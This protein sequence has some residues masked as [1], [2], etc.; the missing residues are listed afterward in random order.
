MV[1]ETKDKKISRTNLGML[2]GIIFGSILAILAFIYTNNAL[3]FILIGVF[4][5]IGLI[6]GS[7]WEKKAS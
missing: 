2:F 6:F 1:A 3:S 4:L 7:L 5:V